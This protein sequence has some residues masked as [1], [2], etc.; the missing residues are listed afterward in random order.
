MLISSLQKNMRGKKSF[1]AKQGRGKLGTFWLL[2][3]LKGMRADRFW[4]RT[5][6]FMPS[7]QTCNMLMRLLNMETYPAPG[8]S[9]HSFQYPESAWGE[10]LSPPSPTHPYLFLKPVIY[11][12]S[13]ALC[14]KCCWM[15]YVAVFRSAVFAAACTKPFMHLV[16]LKRIVKSL[17]F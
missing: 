7:C 11:L 16:K 1:V 17:L 10:F 6:W 5:W 3:T 12:V 4:T 14:L 13:L 8:L 15:C 2:S 9:S